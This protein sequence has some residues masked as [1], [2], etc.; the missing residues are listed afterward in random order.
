MLFAASLGRRKW[1][2][3]VYRIGI[4]GVGEGRLTNE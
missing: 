2:E 4:H 3:A 1:A